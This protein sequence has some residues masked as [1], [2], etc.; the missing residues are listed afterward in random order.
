MD[1]PL[2]SIVTGTFQRRASLVR[3]YESAA[4]QIPRHIPW[5]FIAVDAGSVD[6]TVEWCNAQKNVTLIQ[7]GELRGAIAAFCDGARAAK[8]DFVVLGNDDVVFWPHSIM[9]A[10]SF[11]MEYAD[12]GAVAFADNRS[13]QLGHADGPRVEQAPGIL[14]DG[15]PT[16]LNYA[17][18]G[19]FRRWLGEQVGWWGD[20]DPIMS[21][22]KTYGGDNW[23]SAKIWELGYRVDA[24]EGVGIDDMVMRD[25]LRAGNVVTGNADSQ[26]YYAC[27]PQGPRYP[28]QPVTFHASD[29]P[30]R[31][32]VL[33]IYEPRYPGYMNKEY[34]LSEALTKYGLVY[35]IDYVNSGEDIVSAVKAWRPDILLT[36]C[37]GVSTRINAN[38]LSQC[39]AVKPDMVVVNWNG[40]AHLDGLNSPEIL[41]Y[42]HYVD[43]QLVCNAKVIP[44]YEA[45]GI[46]AAYWQI[47]W[48]EPHGELPKVGK[49]DIVFLGNAYNARRYQLVETLTA[50]DCNVGLYGNLPGSIGNTHYDFAMSAAIY[51]NCK[52]AISDTY[53]GTE[54][55]VSN[56]LFQALG[57]GAFVLQEHSPRLEEFTGL[58]AGIHFI[59]WQDF[60]DLSRL[61]VE[62]LR[63]ARKKERARIAAA[64]RDFVRENYSYDAQVARLWELI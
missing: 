14:P 20:Q 44:E 22:A 5:E 3:F 29:I 55:F 9:R 49:H 17:Q 2:I 45:H 28:G 42:L 54:A 23:L 48:K 1:N 47:A 7:H 12:C 30:L 35:E 37:H 63:P 53:P 24:V 11:M 41:E 13:Q 8:G 50:L 19:M 61:V 33:P 34:G 51:G 58:C 18:V 21:H 15:Q 10:V 32:M 26:A 36:Q 59:E 27:F 16:M 25:G 38:I 31:I 46:R 56:R 43:L 6:G 4:K 64:G 60:D 52:I 62:W 57:S 39:R 40:D